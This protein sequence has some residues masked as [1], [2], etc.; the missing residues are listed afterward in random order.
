VPD[1]ARDAP[2]VIMIHE[3]IFE[4]LDP[5]VIMSA[6]KRVASD[7]GDFLTQF[8]SESLDVEPAY[9]RR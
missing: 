1:S 7:F 5:E 2:V 8:I 3:V 9:P 4:D 6:R